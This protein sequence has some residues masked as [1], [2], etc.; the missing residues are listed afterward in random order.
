MMLSACIV[1]RVNWQHL[2]AFFTKVNMV[3][4]ML[5]PLNEIRWSQNTEKQNRD[6]VPVQ[7]IYSGW[8]FSQAISAQVQLHQIS[9][10]KYN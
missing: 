7:L 8:Y 4:N 9:K 1:E 2:S 10:L 6:V 3:G 5:Y